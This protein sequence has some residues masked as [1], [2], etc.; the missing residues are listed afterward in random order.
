MSW[1]YDQMTED[2]KRLIIINLPRDKD[3]IP[4]NPCARYKTTNG[5]E[6]HLRLIATFNVTV[7]V[8]NRYRTTTEADVTRIQ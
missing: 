2:E 4:M 6:C 5:V 8:D 7:C 3:G 1:D